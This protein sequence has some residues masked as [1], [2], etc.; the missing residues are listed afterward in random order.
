MVKLIDSRKLLVDS[1]KKDE[2]PAGVHRGGRLSGV[3]PQPFQG[4]YVP[5]VSEQDPLALRSYGGWDRPGP[6][7]QCE[8]PAQQCLVSWPGSGPALPR[9]LQGRHQHDFPPD[10]PGEAGGQH[11]PGTG[12]GPRPKISRRPGEE[13]DGVPWPAGPRAADERRP[14]AGAEYW[15]PADCLPSGDE[16]SQCR[17]LSVGPL[18]PGR[19]RTKYP[20]SELWLFS[21][22]E[23]QVHHCG[24]GDPLL[25][26]EEKCGGDTQS[27]QGEETHG[28]T[29]Y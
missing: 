14:G 3:L 25:R 10:W 29:Q 23:I 28:W 9:G 18:C 8:Q 7:V 24:G 16:V 20:H 26:S 11:C 13:A 19:R 21:P 2:L 15:G 5:A 6:G 1:D 27:Y 22:G 4:G 12:P 17:R